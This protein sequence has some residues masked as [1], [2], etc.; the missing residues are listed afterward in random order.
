MLNWLRILNLACFDERAN[1][2][3]FAPLTVIVGSNNTGKSTIINAI[4]MNVLK[5]LRSG[6]WGEWQYHPYGSMNEAVHLHDAN[7]NINIIAKYSIQGNTIEVNYF[8][9][10]AGSESLKAVNEHVLEPFLRE[11]YLY[12]RPQRSSIPQQQGVARTRRIQLISPMGDDIVPFYLERW[13]DRDPK[14]NEAESWLKKI[15]PNL[16]LLKVPLR[17]GNTSLVST[18]TYAGKDVDV[19]LTY[20]GMG[21]QNAA[22][23]IAALV[24]SSNNSII[25]IE[26]PENHINPIIQEH[27]VDL[28]NK[29]VMEWGKQVIFTT[30]SINMLLPYLSDVGTG[31]PRGTGHVKLAPDKFKMIATEWKDGRAAISEVNI[32]EKPLIHLGQGSLERVKELI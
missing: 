25:V 20:Q 9:E 18:S 24:F 11:Q 22:T 12:I 7:R 16:K 17:G 14:W 13:T 27:I 31:K 6:V 8:I 28:M 4:N 32:R 10:H 19:N 29:A 23:I 3:N 26:E 1:D 30:H 21:I 2:I 5:A 15:D